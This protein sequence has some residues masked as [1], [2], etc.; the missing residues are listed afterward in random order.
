MS[1]VDIFEDYE[2]ALKEIERLNAENAAVRETLFSMLGKPY[3]MP[4]KKG[5]KM[6]DDVVKKLIESI[7]KAESKML[8]AIAHGMLT[9]LV[10]RDYARQNKGSC[11]AQQTTRPAVKLP[12]LAEVETKVKEMWAVCKDTDLGTLLT[13]AQLAY[14]F[15]ERKLQA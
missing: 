4:G 11:Q 1:G 12:Q 9:E 15:I 2:S 10:E 7:G 14:S 13:G 3:C 5:F 8:L 6:S